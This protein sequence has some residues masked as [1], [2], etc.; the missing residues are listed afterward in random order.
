MDG[1]G[2]NQRGHDAGGGAEHIAGT[3][4]KAPHHQIDRQGRKRGAEDV[5]GDGKGR[6]RLFLGQ[7]VA[8]DAAGRNDDDRARAAEG[9]AD[10][11]QARIA[12]RPGVVIHVP[13]AIF[14]GG[15]HLRRN[16]FLVRVNRRHGQK[17]SQK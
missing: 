8:N 10:G 4:A 11:Q 7:H 17:A 5:A 3:P 13:E 12:P 16:P 15:G 6:E 1:I 14:G 2:G 9:L